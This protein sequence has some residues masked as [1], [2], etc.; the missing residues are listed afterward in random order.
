MQT[1]VLS[2]D[3]EHDVTFA[4]E[5]QK[6]VTQFLKDHFQ[7]IKDI[8]YLSDGY[9][10]QYKNCQNFNICHHSQ[11]NFNL[12]ATWTYLATSHG[13]FSCDGIRRTIK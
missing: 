5:T 1:N 8:N 9:A 7:K 11:D 10:T 13:K 3:L 12:T 4:Y 6:I 2:D